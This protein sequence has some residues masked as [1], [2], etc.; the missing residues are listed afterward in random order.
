MNSGQNKPFNQLF[1]NSETGISEKMQS[2]SDDLR[3]IFIGR[4]VEVVFVDARERHPVNLQTFS[5]EHEKAQRPERYQGIVND[6]K[7]ALVGAGGGRRPYGKSMLMLA[8]LVSLGARADD[9]IFVGPGGRL[10]D[11]DFG[12]DPFPYAEEVEDLSPHP[13]ERHRQL[14]RKLTSSRSRAGKAARWAS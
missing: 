10:R 14:S 8:A 12:H 3:E 2:F 11:V 1:Q 5:W 9:V 13:G 7:V 4:D 6:P